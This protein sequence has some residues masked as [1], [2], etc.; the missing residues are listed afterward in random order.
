MQGDLDERREKAGNKV[1]SLPAND[2][3]VM[4]LTRKESSLGVCLPVDQTRKGYYA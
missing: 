3:R 1:A 2:T 4:S